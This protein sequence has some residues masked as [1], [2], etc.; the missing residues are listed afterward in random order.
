MVTAG[1]RL[2]MW[3]F[4]ASY[5]QR[6]QLCLFCLDFFEV[7]IADVVKGRSLLCCALCLFGQ[8]KLGVLCSQLLLK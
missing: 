7:V 2:A 6:V 4:V 1:K 8:V 3:Q 5:L